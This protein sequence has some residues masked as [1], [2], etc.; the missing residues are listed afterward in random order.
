MPEVDGGDS[1]DGL[2]VPAGEVL[3]AGGAFELEG[4]RG[5]AWPGGAWGAPPPAAGDAVSVGVASGPGLPTIGELPDVCGL[6]GAAGLA[7]GRAAPELPGDPGC[8]GMLDT[9]VGLLLGV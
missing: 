6:L 3:N 8:P 1:P 9:G 2:G 5:S 4:S 7:G